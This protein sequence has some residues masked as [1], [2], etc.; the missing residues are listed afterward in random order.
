MLK[1][2]KS[3]ESAEHPHFPLAHSTLQDLALCQQML[4]EKG[5]EDLG[6]YRP[7]SLTSVPNKVWRLFWKVL[8]KHLKDNSV[9]G[10][11]NSIIVT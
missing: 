10:L 1:R 3:L 5:K 2:Q 7:V 8:G 9:I 11:F 4:A 6:N